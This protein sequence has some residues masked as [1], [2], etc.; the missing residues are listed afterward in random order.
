MD[1]NT[2]SSI[3]K[4]FKIYRES[5]KWPFCS[6]R[7]ESEK[8]ISKLQFFVNSAI[9]EKKEDKL[10]ISLLDICEWKTNNRVTSDYHKTLDDLGEAYLNI[11]ISLSP[12]NN[13]EKLENL[14]NT[15]HVENCNLPLCSA[16]ASFLF[17]RQNVP[18]IDRY[19][20]LFFAR[21]FKINSVDKETVS[22]TRF[23]SNHIIQI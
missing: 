19:L 18:I 12:F 9:S 2:E 14:I 4:W 7:D 6:E 22:D 11:L 17:N 23:Y 20:A 16:I 3:G 5:Y 15:L 1:E 13:T 10:K 21:E 8:R